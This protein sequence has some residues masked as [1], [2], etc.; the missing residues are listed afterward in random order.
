MVARTL[1]PFDPAVVA[2]WELGDGPRSALLLH[3]FSGTPPELR[4]LGVRLAAE[5]WHCSAPVLAGHGTTPE[6][7]ERTTRHDW[8]RSAARALEALFERTPD[9]VVVGQSMGGTIAL[10]LAATDARVSAVATLAAPVRIH[11]WRI[12]LLP[13]LRRVQRW[14]YPGDDIDL[15]DPAA[16]AELH[17]YGR[18]ST[19]AVSQFLELIR[20][21]RAELP[22]VRQPVLLLH[23]AGD[24]TVLPSNLWEIQSRLVC[25][26]SVDAVLMP[27]S[28]HGMSVDVE[29]GE[30]ED[31][32]AAF[33]TG[34]V[35]AVRP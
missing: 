13:L 6:D 17:S 18:R 26:A 24:R 34:V 4:R 9:V 11:D 31:R 30:I 27:R 25:A 8:L 14:T 32:V 28:G 19:A 3:G 35:P 22:L 7:Q 16:I 12:P 20:D 10:H 29:R 2:P 21:V 15:A 5:G 33:L 1:E 23:G